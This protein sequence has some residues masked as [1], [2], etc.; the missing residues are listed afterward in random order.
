[1]KQAGEAPIERADDHKAC[2][3][4]IKIFHGATFFLSLPQLDLREKQ[5]YCKEQEE[6]VFPLG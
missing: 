1:M 5:F 6:D 3:E 4:Y 2:G